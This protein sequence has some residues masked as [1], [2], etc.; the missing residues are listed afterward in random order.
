MKPFHNVCHFDLPGM[1]IRVQNGMDAKTIL[2]IRR[3]HPCSF[4]FSFERHLP[5]LRTTDA[6]AIDCRCGGGFRGPFVASNQRGLPGEESKTSYQRAYLYTRNPLYLGSLLAGIGFS[7]AGGRWWFFLLLGFLEVAV[8]WPVIRR[9]EAHLRKLFPEEFDVYARSV[10]VL[11]PRLLPNKKLQA[12][13]ECFR[14]D[15]YWR[16]REYQ[17]SK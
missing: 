10:P 9:E 13:R 15:L 4:Q 17:A 14:W 5:D 6:R 3:S 7:I 1:P 16:N 2:S 12:T 8:Y 11:L